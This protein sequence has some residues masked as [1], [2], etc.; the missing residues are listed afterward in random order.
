MSNSHKFVTPYDEEKDTSP[1]KWLQRQIHTLP[2][3]E[4]REGH[5]VK[6]LFKFQSLLPVEK[7]R[8]LHAIKEA[9]KGKGDVD[10]IT[11]SDDPSDAMISVPIGLIA[12][13]CKRNPVLSEEYKRLLLRSPSGTRDAAEY[14]LPTALALYNAIEPFVNKHIAIEDNIQRL[15][16]L[17]LIEKTENEENESVKRIQK[18]PEN[19]SGEEPKILYQIKIRH[20]FINEKEFLNKGLGDQLN[21]ALGHKMFTSQLNEKNFGTPSAQQYTVLEITEGDLQN[22]RNYEKAK[23]IPNIVNSFRNG[24]RSQFAPN[25]GSVLRKFGFN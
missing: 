8:V 21:E 5:Q 17:F 9:L 3:I 19:R 7:D 16:G 22:L 20:A 18:S 2:H 1:A 6:V 14:D 23:Q 10:K 4:D 25:V 11:A 15:E 13:I 24:N 12:P